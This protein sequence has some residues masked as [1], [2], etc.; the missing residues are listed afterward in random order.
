MQFLEKNTFTFDRMMLSTKLNKLFYRGGIL[1]D[2]T[3]PIKKMELFLK[4]NKEILENLAE[5]H[6]EKINWHIKRK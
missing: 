3:I 4:E 5:K 6:I 1:I 2:V